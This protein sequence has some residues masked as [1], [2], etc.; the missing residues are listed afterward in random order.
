MGLK[1]EIAPKGIS[2]EITLRMDIDDKTKLYKYLFELSEKVGLRLRKEKKYA[3]VL[4]VILKDK[5]FKRKTHQK[6][7]DNPIHT[8]EDIYSFSKVV[9]NE[10]WDNTSVRLIGIRLEKL[11]D[12]LLIQS[13]LFDENKIE[14]KNKLEDVLDDINAKYSDIVVTRA[15]ERKK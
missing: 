11:T 3:N 6:K 14:E 5:Y 2:N 7:L 10:M 8:T 9:L 1:N 4:A 13:S 15:V 12:K